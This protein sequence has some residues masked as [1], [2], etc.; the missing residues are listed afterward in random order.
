MY[1]GPSPIHERSVHLILSM[2]SP[3]FHVRFNNF[4]EIINGK[5]LPRSECQYKARPISPRVS[6][7]PE[8]DPATMTKMILPKQPTNKVNDVNLSSQTDM[9]LAQIQA[10]PGENTENRNENNSNSY[11]TLET[12]IEIK[13]DKT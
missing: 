4:F 1:L 11:T 8:L 9:N 6:K 7:T 2:A 13:N 12:P 10:D 5:K 3:Q